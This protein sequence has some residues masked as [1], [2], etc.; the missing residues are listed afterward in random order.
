[1]TESEGRCAFTHD[2]LREALLDGLDP[3]ERRR[4]HLAAAERI[5]AVDPD[6]AFELAYHFDAG[7]ETAR[8]LPYALRSGSRGAGAP[9][10]R[11]RGDPLPRLRSAPRSAQAALSARVAEELGEV[12]M[13][14]GDYPGR[15]TPS[16]E[17]ALELSDD[18]VA[19]AIINGKL[20]D[21]AFKQGDQVNAA[22]SLEGA[23]RALGRWVPRSRFTTFVAVVFEA[24][25]QCLHTL[26]PRPFVARR[27]AERGAEREFVAIRLYSN[28][29]HVYWFSAGK[30]SCAWAHLREMNLAERYPAQPRAGP[31][32]L[33]ACAGDDHG[34]L[35]LA[36]P[37]LR[38]ALAGH[39][40]RER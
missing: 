27:R 22:R 34:A 17:R 19:R 26:L 6:R 24:L 2:K 38:T 5:E 14:Q 4:L 10:P 23:L 18:A 39:S 25:V 31:G 35:V 30:F 8:A 21:V 13:L 15:D 7:G 33:G 20:G 28:L 9:C 12:L 29:A 36:W 37:R 32:V 40:T 11:C 1:M 3:A 16:C